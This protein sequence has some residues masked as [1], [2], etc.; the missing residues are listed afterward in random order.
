M[1]LESARCLSYAR[2]VVA[3]R[4]NCSLGHREQANQATSYLDG[5][6]I[7]GSTTGKARKLRSFKNGTL[8]AAA[9]CAHSADLQIH[10][11]VD[12][13]F[14]ASTICSLCCSQT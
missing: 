4:E 11:S 7:Y 2:S 6:H 8:L 5:S 3:P 10:H 12:L 9:S 13:Q 1:F 14:M